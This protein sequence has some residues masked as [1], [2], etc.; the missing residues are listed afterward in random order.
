MQQI[1]LSTAPSE[2]EW[3]ARLDELGDELGAF[4]ALGAHHAAVYADGDDTL[5]VSF[6]SLPEIRAHS[7]DHRPLGLR[8]AAEHGWSSLVVVARSPRWFRDTEVL[9]FFDAQI[10]AAF[11]ES[12][13]RV[14]FTGCGMGGYAACAF[15]LAAPGA[16]VL[17]VAPQA[18]LDPVIAPWD[19]RFPEAR[20]LEFDSRFGYAPD[21]LEGARNVVVLHDPSRRSDSMH[22]TLFRQPHVTVLRTPRLHADTATALRRMDLLAPLVVQAAE[23]RLSADTVHALLRARRDNARYLRGLMRASAQAGHPALTAV[24]A[25]RAHAARHRPR[26]PRARPARVPATP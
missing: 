9:D 7:T 11:F 13:R 2:A 25:Q 22:A 10:D 12:F 20:R 1:D 6:E 21:M 4:T 24:A 15:S 26:R 23:D 8:L 19:R 17:A 3:L 16:T 5:V 18:T 14:V